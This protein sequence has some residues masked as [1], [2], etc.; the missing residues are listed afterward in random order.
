VSTP[1]PPGPQRDPG[2][3][4]QPENLVAFPATGASGAAAAAAPPFHTQSSAPGRT[5]TRPAVSRSSPGAKRLWSRAAAGT[6]TT[7]S[8]SSSRRRC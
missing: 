6:S 3:I 7:W 8:P 5:R 2:V 4:P 1:S